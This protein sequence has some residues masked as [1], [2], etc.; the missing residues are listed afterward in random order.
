MNF[1]ENLKYS[2]EHTW[3]LVDG[4][5]G[6]AGITEFAQGELGEIVFVN[7]PAIGT[8]FNENEVFG[9]IEALKTVS[10]LFMPVSGKVVAV[11]DE[12]KVNPTFV[13]DD[14]YN[15]GWLIKIRITDD[16][17]LNSLLNTGQYQQKIGG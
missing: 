12:L 3:L 4:D 2:T 7:L 16:A 15:K 5:S 9:T 14:P 11:N 8:S 1:P 10:D 6:T 17:E 13:N